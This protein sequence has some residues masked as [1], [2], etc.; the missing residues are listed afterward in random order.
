M[1]AALISYRCDTALLSMRH[2]AS[3]DVYDFRMRA[4]DVYDFH[5]CS[6]YILPCF[7][8]PS[9]L[10]LSQY[11]PHPHYIRRFS[12]IVSI[13]ETRAQLLLGL[14]EEGQLPV[15]RQNVEGR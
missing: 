11:N 8:I 10:F 6:L 12:N 5:S 2:T 1:D 15:I 4:I 7:A 13:E 14:E 9:C 3:I